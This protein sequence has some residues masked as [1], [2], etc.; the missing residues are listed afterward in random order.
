LVE[1]KVRHE[2]SNR[3]HQKDRHH[4]KRIANDI[5]HKI[6]REIFNQAIETNAIIV[7]GNIK[8]LRKRKQKQYRRR[9]A[10][11]LAGFPYHELMQYIRYKAALAG[12]KVIELSEAW[13]SQT[14]SKCR[15]KGHRK[16]QGL[17]V[18]DHCCSE[19]NADRNAAFNIAKRGLVYTSKLGVVVNLPRT[20]ARIDRNPMMIGGATELVQ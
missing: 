4:E 6:S 15:E 19:D 10:R 9:M 2:E 14:C 7:L 3:H 12:I 11:L 13:T 8:Y 20:P 5:V 18:C 16:T 1:K 17:F